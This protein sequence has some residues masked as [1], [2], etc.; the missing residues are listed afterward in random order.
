MSNI[1]SLKDRVISVF[2]NYTSF[3]VSCAVLAVLSI[4]IILAIVFSGNGQVVTNEGGLNLGDD[5]PVSS[6]PVGSV[7]SYSLPLLNATLLKGYYDKELVYNDSL[8]QW[9][10]HRSWDL[11][12]SDSTSVM[13]IADGVVKSVNAL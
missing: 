6:T 8:K 13:S 10:T 3:I 1:Y 5:T 11:V 4:T 9:E 12:S 2:R 7:V